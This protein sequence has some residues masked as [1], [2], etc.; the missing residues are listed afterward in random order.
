VSAPERQHGTR[1]TYRT[2]CRC[3]SCRAANAKAER[4][5]LAELAVLHG[6]QLRF[7]CST[8]PMLDHI[9]H[10]RAQGWTVPRIAV[11]VGRDPESF[12]QSLRRGRTTSETVRRVLAVR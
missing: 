6:G 7:F 3:R 12:R 5:R 8:A 4:L 11:A 10:L 1:A 9:E 2:G